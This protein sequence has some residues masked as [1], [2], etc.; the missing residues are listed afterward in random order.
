M[1]K[2]RYM[3]LLVLVSLVFV[4][5]QS[6]ESSGDK[7]GDGVFLGGSEGLA[8]QFGDDAPAI[9]GN[10]Q[11]EAFPIDVD[12]TN[13]GETEV[14]PES[15]FVYL[16]GA[17][18]SSSAVTTSDPD[19]VETNDV[20]IDAIIEG[21]DGI[22]KDRIV[23]PLGTATYTG[24]ILGDSVPLDVRVSVCYP[25]ETRVQ[26]DDFCIPS[27]NRLA[28]NQDCEVESTVN[29]IEENDNSGAPIHVTSVREQQGPDFVRVTLDIN[30]VGT[31]QVING[32]CK[33][34]VQR[35]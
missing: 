11:N 31:G 5:G 9:S 19:K 26:V 6:C 24:N 1:K 18:Q 35:E 15:A 27:T 2:K 13:K 17:L 20:L 12:L 22:V 14:G 8:I 3:I 34:D 21:E 16:T 28:G 7:S 29:I 4:V 10:F 25:Y 30:N 33:R 23:V 32:F